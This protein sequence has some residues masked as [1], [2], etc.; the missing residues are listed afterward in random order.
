MASGHPQRTPRW[1]RPGLKGPGGGGG[2]RELWASG[3]S[4]TRPGQRE[5]LVVVSRQGASA[6]KQTCSLNA[7]PLPSPFHAHG[8]LLP[9]TVLLHL[10]PRGTFR[11]N[12][13]RR[14]L[15]VSKNLCCA[16]VT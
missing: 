9:L 14:V 16:G 11:G 1:L 15:Q 3:A 5:L 12:S 4:R 13:S 8:S 2:V 6:L 7:P 10:G